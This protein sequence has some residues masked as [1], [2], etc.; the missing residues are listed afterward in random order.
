MTTTNNKMTHDEFIA[1]VLAIFPEAGI[2]YDFE[3]QFVIYTN[4]RENDEGVI[5]S[6]DEPR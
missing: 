1:T 6:M 4:L 5:V 2:H 3:D